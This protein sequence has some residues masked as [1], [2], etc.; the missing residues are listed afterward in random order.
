MGATP[1][2]PGP[3]AAQASIPSVLASSASSRPCRTRH[4]S[5]RPKPPARCRGGPFQANVLSKPKGL[6]PTLESMDWKTRF[7]V[8]L[9]LLAALILAGGVSAATSMKLVSAHNMATRMASHDESQDPAESD[10][11]G[12]SEPPEESERP[13][14]SPPDQSYPTESD[15]RGIQAVRWSGSTRAATSP[16]ALLRSRAT[17]PMA[18]T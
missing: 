1:C 4:P 8:G 7:P 5:F 16:R 11:P 17:G 3:G 10:D 12:D 18:S 14:E 13:D 9:A 6:V 2:A 15:A